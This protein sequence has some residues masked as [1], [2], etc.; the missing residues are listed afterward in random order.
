[1]YVNARAGAETSLYK[2]AFKSKITLESV[3]Q[4]IMPLYV[5]TSETI[6]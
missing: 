2:E 1:M 5:A 3:I 6:A 4:K